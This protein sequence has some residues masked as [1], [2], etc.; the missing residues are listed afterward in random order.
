MNKEWSE[1]NKTMQAQ[2]KKEAG[3]QAGINTL[4]TLR[5]QLMDILISFRQNLTREDFDAIPF[6]NADGYHCKTI[7]YSIWHIFRIEDIVAH[8]LIN[9]D[10]Q[11]FFKN[12]YQ[13][14]IGSTI[15]TTG[16]ELVKQQIA[17]FSK[18][19]DLN[20][21]YAYIS[22][23]KQSTEQIVKK[24]AF[25]DLKRNIT[26]ETKEYL[27]SLHV[28]S[29]DEKSIWLIDYWCGKDIRGLIQMPFSRHWIMHVEA[30]LKI[31]NKIHP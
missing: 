13:K 26:E 9:E 2:L 5:N 8:T 22:E 17:D 1:L 24:F 28:V 21:L 31:Q 23:V 20:E 6:I 19:L 4:I 14:R 10:E 16:N 15:I 27:K 7:A 12:H 18:K 30:C 29:D 3:L 25:K 11:I